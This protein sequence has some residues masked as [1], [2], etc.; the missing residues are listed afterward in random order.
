MCWW[1]SANRTLRRDVLGRPEAA[2]IAWL[3]F[4]DGVFAAANRLLCGQLFGRIRNVFLASIAV[5]N[6]DSPLN[7]VEA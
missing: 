6:V 3:G 7:A 5:S 2:F 1:P 4:R